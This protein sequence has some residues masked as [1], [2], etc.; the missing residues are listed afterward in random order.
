VSAALVLA[1]LGS[2]AYAIGCIGLDQQAAEK[3]PSSFHC[4]EAS[5]TPIEDHLDANE[6]R[7]RRDEAG[8]ERVGFDD[9]A[10][11]LGRLA[12]T[13]EW[14]VPLNGPYLRKDPGAGQAADTSQP[15]PADSPTPPPE[16]Q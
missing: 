1:T 11:A 4:S 13:T 5:K 3:A 6:A 12:R 8:T 14:P 16:P 15:L 2:G 9:V 7:Q 10:K